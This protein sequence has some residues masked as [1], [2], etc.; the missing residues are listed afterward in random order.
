M[1]T[2]QYTFQFSDGQ[3]EEITT[4]GGMD[5]NRSYPEWTL[6]QPQACSGCP[7][8]KT[9]CLHCPMAVSIEPLVRLA[10]GRNSF[11]EVHVSVKSSSR[12]YTKT[13]TIQHAL[14]SLMG[15][16]SA[17]S[18]CPRT[19]FL[20]A[21]ARYHLPFSTPEETLYRVTSAYLLSQFFA[22]QNG[23]EPDW[24]LQ[25]LRSNYSQLQNVNR[26]MAERI[27]TACEKDGAINALILL[28]TLAKVLQYSIDEELEL[29]R[30]VFDYTRNKAS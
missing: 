6:L 13:T 2:F 27:R 9:D 7:L 12:N 28:D 29:I 3:T 11:D 15:L 19:Q 10:A 1:S 26:M 21:M 5:T 24:N 22:Q 16:L 4:G 17:T 25:S 14:G 23:M 30:P 20:G 8:A 18:G